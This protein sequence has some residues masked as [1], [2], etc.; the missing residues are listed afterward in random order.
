MFM[1]TKLFTCQSSYFLE[2]NLL[3]FRK[4]NWMFSIGELAID[5]SLVVEYMVAT[6]NECF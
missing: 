3:V 1:K 4:L 5:F 6:V 2:F